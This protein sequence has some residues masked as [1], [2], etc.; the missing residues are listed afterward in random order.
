[1]DLPLGPR[2]LLMFTFGMDMVLL[3]PKAIFS[4]LN[5]GATMVLLKAGFMSLCHSLDER[6]E[7]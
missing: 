1:M 4:I 7:F 3:V 2:Y 5:L 6:M